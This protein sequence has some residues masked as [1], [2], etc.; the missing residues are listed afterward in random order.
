LSEKKGQGGKDKAGRG[1]EIPSMM[2]SNVE[3]VKKHAAIVCT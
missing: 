1:N 3:K 2:Y